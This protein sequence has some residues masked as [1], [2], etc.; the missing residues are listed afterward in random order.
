MISIALVIFAL[1]VTE[2]T[3]L[4]WLEKAEVLSESWVLALNYFFAAWIVWFFEVKALQIKID[5]VWKCTQHI[6][7]F[8]L[9]ES[10]FPFL[11]FSFSFF[12]F[13]STGRKEPGTSFSNLGEWRKTSMTVPRRNVIGFF[14]WV[15]K[16]SELV[17]WACV[18]KS[19][20][21][22]KVPHSHLALEYLM[23]IAHPLWS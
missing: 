11:F 10:F 12:I 14:T 21:H 2:Q 13:M 7:S 6:L 20:L 5:V 15:L 17:S 1:P 9:R 23:W 3:M 18:C 19:L 8:I 16:I 22:Y 4:Y